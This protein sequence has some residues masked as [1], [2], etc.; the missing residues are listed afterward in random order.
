MTDRELD[1]DPD[2]LAM[3]RQLFRSEAHDALEAVTARVLASGSVGPSPEAL[4]EM[5]RATHT[6]KGAAGTVGLPAMV[7]LSHRLEN[8]FAAFG[9]EPSLW[10]VGT[11]DVLVE[12]V[13]ALRSYLD[14]MCEPG[15][16]QAADELRTTIDQIVPA[17]RTGTLAVPQVEPTHEMGPDTGAD[18]GA[19][20]GGR[21]PA[22]A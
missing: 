5:M 11:A 14:M 9:R 3:L 10:T 17:R 20:A 8:V 4:T 22:A 18:T 6:L 16:D 21:V 12:V 19:D 13:D 7:D 2:E 1:F 15:A